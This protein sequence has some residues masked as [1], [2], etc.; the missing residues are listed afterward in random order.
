MAFLPGFELGG[1]WVFNGAL[2]VRL[3]VLLLSWMCIV[4]SLRLLF[5]DCFYGCKL[6]RD[7]V[8]LVSL[9]NQM[10]GYCGTLVL[11]MLI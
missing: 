6:S 2:H 8:E 3:D 11:Y 5:L 9:I 1:W 4:V 10:N 7:T